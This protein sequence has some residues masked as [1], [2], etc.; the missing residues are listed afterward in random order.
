MFTWNNDTDA[1]VDFAWANLDAAEQAALGGAATG[2][3]VISWLQG[4]NVSGMRS[5]S[6]KGLMGDVLNSDPVFLSYIDSGYTKLPPVSGTGYD[7]YAAYVTS[8][9]S[10]TAMIYVGANDGM[11]HG[12]DAMTGEEKMTFLPAGIYSDWNDVNNNG[13]DDD[14][15]M[16]Q[17]QKLLNLTSPS[18]DHRYFVDG[19]LTVG[20]AHAGGS[21]GTYLVGGLGR[22]GRSV[23]ALDV[24][25]TSYTASSTVKWEF[26]DPDLGYTYGTPII[27]RL[28]NNKWY[29]IFPNGLDSNG[30][31]ARVFLVNLN[32]RTDVI[33][34]NTTTTGPNGM[35][36]VQ[37]KLNSERT[38]TD[39]Y[40][41]DMQ[42]NIWKFNVYDDNGTPTDTSDDTADTSPTAVKLFTA[43]SGQAITGG[44]RVGNHPDG[45]GT[46]V[47]FGTGKYFETQDN[48]FNGSSVP[49]VDS[50]YAVLDNGTTTGITPSQLQQQSFT[51][52]GTNLR[53][54]TQTAVPYS[55]AGSKMGWYID[56]LN[57][58]GGKMG[59]RVVSTPVLYGGRVIF[60]SIIPLQ[61]G[62]CGGEGSSWLNELDALTGGMLNDKV[63]DT[64]GDGKLDSADT[65]V[66]SMQLEGLASD[67]SVVLGQDH[68][69][70]VIGSTS[71]TSSVQVVGETKPV[72][73]G[74]EDDGR[75]GRMSWR[76][77]Q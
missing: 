1:G 16:N 4:N 53:T 58:S 9:K 5:H 70:K 13:V 22:G 36:A 7:T 27:A 50:F 55:G 61:G 43:A 57:G 67:P 11:L 18:Y 10:R 48:I 77:L 62:T 41:G 26:S 20:D 68:D 21:W 38:V 51:M 25:N 24:T 74:G 46:L 72:G 3:N 8:S 23:F 64:N 28:A 75:K 49:Q 35:M 17:E 39:I 52:S 2:A 54:S 15:A 19:S 66:S 44:I 56:L 40:A 32:D 73:S 71:T 65:Q 45:L 42:G 69:Y 31:Q 29:A 60:V 12:I 59:E 37:V 33:K 14:G 30:D 63:L 76:Q 34:L 6:S 47:F